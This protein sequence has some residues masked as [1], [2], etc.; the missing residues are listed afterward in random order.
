MEISIPLDKM[1]IDEKIQAM[2]TIWDD[3]CQKADSLSSPDWHQQV[4]QEREI[5]I[6]EGREEFISLEKAKERILK[7][8]Q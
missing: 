7:S 2:E 5:G 3:L 1:S 8:T 4:L 6:K